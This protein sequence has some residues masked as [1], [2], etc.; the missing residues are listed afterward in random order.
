MNGAQK[1]TPPRSGAES[2]IYGKT[3]H[4]AGLVQ[5]VRNLVEIPVSPGPRDR[6]RQH[7]LI[8]QQV[9]IRRTG[10]LNGDGRAR[11]LR[12]RRLGLW[13]IGLAAVEVHSRLSA[14]TAAVTATLV[15][16]AFTTATASPPATAP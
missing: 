14:A 16:T 5:V 15:A 4:A 8:V 1:S 6:L 7:R 13:R 9:P 12:A 3:L 10:P 2:A 11:L